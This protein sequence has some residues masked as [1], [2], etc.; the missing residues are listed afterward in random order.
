MQVSEAIF[1]YLKGELIPHIAG[2]SEMTAAILNGVLRA[3]RKRIAG[4]V[5][6]NELIRNLGLLDADGRA[7]PEMAKEFFAGM[8]DGREKVSI[9]M[10]EIVKLLTGV[11]SSSVLLQDKLTFTAADAEKFIALLSN[12]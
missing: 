2:D 1:E 9:T 8:F 12:E 6:Q 10:A 11:E 5:S 3:S 4:A 7:D